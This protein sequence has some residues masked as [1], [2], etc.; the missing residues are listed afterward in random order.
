MPSRKEKRSR[1]NL[2]NKF[3]KSTSALE[4][5]KAC[6]SLNLLVVVILENVEKRRDGLNLLPYQE[7]C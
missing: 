3:L 4:K 5:N 7:A 2:K 6:N 1:E